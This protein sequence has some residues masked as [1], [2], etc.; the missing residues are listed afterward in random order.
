MQALLYNFLKPYLT[1]HI[2]YLPKSIAT[3]RDPT[4][5]TNKPH[6][7]DQKKQARQDPAMLVSIYTYRKGFT[8]Q[9]EDA[10]EGRVVR[11]ESKPNRSV[12]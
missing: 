10:C 8:L 9:Q 5:T 11:R 2:L 4:T 1:E 12:A 7:Y 3:I 6:I